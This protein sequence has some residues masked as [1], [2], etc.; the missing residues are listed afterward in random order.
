MGAL[1]LPLAAAERADIG[2]STTGAVIERLRVAGPSTTVVLIGGLEGRDESSARVEQA[3]RELEKLQPARRPFRLLAVPLANPDATPLQ[4]PPSGVAYRENIES[5]VLWRWL[6]T[7]AP[8]LVLI[9]GGADFG[10]AQALSSTEVAEVG[11]IPAQLVPALPDLLTLKPAISAAHREMERRRGRTPRQLADELAKYYG[12]DFDQPWYIQ[13]I[14]LI[15]QVRL[16]H[17]DEVMRLVEPYVDGTKNSL[18]RPN[19]LVL[20]GHM[21]FTELARRTGDPRYV[22]MVRKV[23]DLGFEPDGTMKESMPYHDEYSDSVFMGTVMPA[24][25]GALTGERKYFDLAARHVAFMQK[26]V[27]RPDGLYR[28]QPLTDPAWGRGNAFAAIGL[29]LALS[30]FPQ[31]HP[32]RAR[33][34]RDFQ[35]HMSVLARWQTTDGLWRNVVDYP[36]AYPEFSATAMIGWAMLRGVRNGWLPAGEYQPRVEKAWRAVLERVGPEGHVIDGC[37]STLKMKSVDDYLHRA[38]ILAPDPRSGAMAL[39][40]ATERLTH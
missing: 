34:L 2:L 5:N 38:A 7:Q 18:Q 35:S 37:E 10:L 28:H 21:I 32:D 12:H 27:L 40:F 6:G 19:S 26:I 17:I 36:G 31:D 8:D 30:E 14:A 9:V 24:Q 3:A 33:L 20:A 15:A 29:A 39:L 13:A 4:F 1:A 11:R 25:A 22:Q 23:A 16:G